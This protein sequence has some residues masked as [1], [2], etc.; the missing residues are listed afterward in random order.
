VPLSYV[1]M[2]QRAMYKL[3]QVLRLV[4]PHM[5]SKPRTN[6]AFD[7]VTSWRSAGPYCVVEMKTRQQMDIRSLLRYAT[8]PSVDTDESIQDS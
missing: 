7:D 2:T 4:A 5:E 3:V 1:N 6:V 8:Q